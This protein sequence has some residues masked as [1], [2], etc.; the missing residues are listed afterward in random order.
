VNEWDDG[1][2]VTYF[3]TKE[4]KS[5]IRGKIQQIQEMVNQ[6]L[7]FGSSSSAE[8]KAEKVCPPVTPPD[9]L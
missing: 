3:S 5:F 4:T 9:S 7:G 1:S 6:Q 8:D 2:Y